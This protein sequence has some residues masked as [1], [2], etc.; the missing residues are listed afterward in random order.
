MKAKLKRMVS[1]C[2]CLTGGAGRGLLL[3]AGA[4]RAFALAVA[5]CAGGSAAFAGLQEQINSASDGTTLTMSADHEDDLT[6]SEAKT[7]NIDMAGHKITG[8]VTTLNGGKLTFKNGDMTCATEFTGPDVLLEKGVRCTCNQKAYLDPEA[9]PKLLM[10][11]KKPW[12]VVYP[13]TEIVAERESDRMQYEDLKTAFSVVKDGQTIRLLTD[14]REDVTVD[15]TVTFDMQGHLLKGAITAQN[16]GTPRTNTLQNVN[17]TGDL[18]AQG[19][20]RIVMQSG[21]NTFGSAFTGTNLEFAEDT[22]FGYKQAKEYIANDMAMAKTESD[23]WQVVNT[24][25]LEAA[26]GALTDDY[27]ERQAFLTAEDAVR[28]AGNGDLIRLLADQSEPIVLDMTAIGKNL[29][30]DA[31]GHLFASPALVG[32]TPDYVIATTK[33]GYLFLT[34]STELVAQL[35]D[36]SVYTSIAAAVAQS[37]NGG[38][39]TLLKDWT[40]DVTV[41]NKTNSFTLGSFTLNGN[42]KTT[43]EAGKIWFL[44]GTNTY[45]EK[46]AGPNVELMNGTFSSYEQEAY[47]TE[48]KTLANNVTTPPTWTIVDTND[49]VAITADGQKFVS[50]DLAMQ[51]AGNGETITFARAY[52]QAGEDDI[53]LDAEALAKNLKF[54]PKGYAFPGSLVYVG[55]GYTTAMDESYKLYLAADDAIVA[56]IAP[57][58]AFTTLATAVAVAKDGDTVEIVKTVNENVDVSGDKVISLTGGTNE[59]HLAF[60]SAT[61]KLTIKSGTYG[62][63]QDQAFLEDGNVFAKVAASLWEVVPEGDIVA[64]TDDGELYTSF[65]TAVDLNGDDTVISFYADFEGDIVLTPDEIAKVPKFNLNGKTFTGELKAASGVS[66]TYVV[67]TTAEGYLYLE[68]AD[69]IVAEIDGTDKQFASIAA[70]LAIA[71]DGEKIN[72]LKSW[73][74]D[75]SLSGQTNKL[76]LGAYE[77]TGDLTTTDDAGKIVVLDGTN[78]WERAFTGPNLELKPGTT[79]GFKQPADFLPSDEFALAK[80][81]ANRWTV[82]ETN[83]LAV[84][85]GEEKFKT[86]EEAIALASSGDTLVFLKKWDADVIVDADGLSKNLKFNPG[87]GLFDQDPMRIKADGYRLVQNPDR[88]FTLKP[89]GWVASVG[90]GDDYMEFQTFLDAMD[91]ADFI[92][93]KEITFL[94]DFPDD[95]LIPDEYVDAGFEFNPAG[96]AFPGELVYDENYTTAMNDATNLF[97]AATDDIV[98]VYNH[99]RPRFTNVVTAVNLAMNGTVVTVVKDCAGDATV[100]ADIT[101]ETADG[102]IYGGM[103]ETNGTCSLT[104]TLGSKFAQNMVDKFDW[105][106]MTPKMTLRHMLPDHDYYEVVL[107]DGTSV[108]DVRWTNRPT[109]RFASVQTAFDWLRKFIDENPDEAL[110]TFGIDVVGAGE[111][112]LD[113]GDRQLNW[114][115]NVFCAEA[116]ITVVNGEIYGDF[117]V[118]KGDV[119]TVVFGEGLLMTNK[120]PKVFKEPADPEAGVRLW[121]E[122]GVYKYDPTAYCHEGYVG[123]MYADRLYR[124]EAK[125][126]V[127]IVMTD[128]KSGADIHFKTLQDAFDAAPTLSTLRLYNN[129][130]IVA[131]NSSG[132]LFTLTSDPQGSDGNGANTISGGEIVLANGR[133]TVSNLVFD[134]AK[135]IVEDDGGILTAGNGLVMKNAVNGAVIVGENDR[136]ILDGNAQIVDN[137]GTNVLVKSTDPKSVVLKSCGDVLAG[138]GNYARVGIWSESCAAGEVFGTVDPT[139]EYGKSF[140]PGGDVEHTFSDGDITVAEPRVSFVND[141]DATLHHGK[142][143]TI[144]APA[145]GEKSYKRWTGG[146][147]EPLAEGDFLLYRTGNELVWTARQDAPAEE[148]DFAVIGRTAHTL[149]FLPTNGCDYAVVTNG[150][151]DTNWV[152]MVAGKTIAADGTFTFTNLVKFTDYQFLKRYSIT[153]SNIVSDVTVIGVPQST[154]SEDIDDIVRD[155]GF[156]PE[157]DFWKGY[158]TV[159][160]DGN[161]PYDGY[162]VTLKKDLR[163]GTVLPDDIGRLVINLNDSYISAE[164]GSN[165]VSFVSCEIEGRAF[166]DQ[167]LADVTVNG[168]GRVVGGKGTDGIDATNAKEGTRADK[169]AA[170]AGAGIAAKGCHDTVAL[171]L[172]SGVEVYGGGYIRNNAG[173]TFGNGGFGIEEDGGKGCDG[174]VGVGGDIALTVDGAFVKGG[175]GGDGGSS[176]KANGGDGG[177]GASAIGGKVEILKLKD[178]TFVGGKGGNG[179]NSGA[180]TGAAGNGGNGGN[181]L[182]IADA[183]K[184]EGNCSF[185]GGDAGKGGVGHNGAESGEDGERGSSGKPAAPETDVQDVVVTGESISFTAEPYMI[186]DLVDAGGNVIDTIVN[187]TDTPAPARF[188]DIGGALTPDTVYTIAS[189][190]TANESRGE[191]ESYAHETQVTTTFYTAADIVA[192]FQ[193]NAEVAIDDDGN[194]AITLTGDVAGG[195]RLPEDLGKVSL[196]LAGKTIAGKDGEVGAPGENGTAAV[197][198]VASANVPK[199]PVLIDLTLVGD[200]T[201]AGGQ[202]GDGK[203]ENPLDS[204]NGGD[205]APAIANESTVDDLKVVL[206]GPT[207]QGG[208]GGK[209]DDALTGNGGKGGRG[210]DAVG[211]RI[212]IEYVSGKAIGGNGGDGGETRDK[213]A[214]A[215]GG[216]GGN[217]GT[218]NVYDANGDFVSD[219]Q[220]GDGGYGGNGPVPGNVDPVSGQQ[221]DNAG[222]GATWGVPGGIVT[223]D[224]GEKDVRKDI[225]VRIGDADDVGNVRYYVSLEDALIDAENATSR[226]VYAIRDCAL[227]DFEVLT[228]GLTLATEG[229]AKIT[230]DGDLTVDSGL[231]FTVAPGCAIETGTDGELVVCGDV[232]LNAGAFAKVTVQNGGSLWVGGGEIAE[233][234]VQ[235]GG[236]AVIGDACEIGDVTVAATGRFT[237]ELNVDVQVTGTISAAEP[238]EVFLFG[239]IYAED[240]SAY[241]RLPFVTEGE[242][243]LKVVQDPSYVAMGVIDNEVAPYKTVDEAFAAIR[244][245]TRLIQVELLQDATVTTVL[246]NQPKIMAV[247]VGNGHTLTDA[248]EDSEDALFNL[249]GHLVIMDLVVDGAGQNADFLR[250]FESKEVA[251]MGCKITGYD[252]RNNLGQGPVISAWAAGETGLLLWNTEITGNSCSCA[253]STVDPSGSEFVHP[254]HVR[255][256]TTITEN[257]GDTGAAP[258]IVSDGYGQIVMDDNLTGGFID[259]AYKGYGE[260]FG[261]FAVAANDQ[262]SGAEKFRYLDQKT[263]GKIVVEA[264]GSAVVEWNLD[265]LQH[266][267][268]ILRPNADPTLPPEEIFEEDVYDAFYDVEDGDTIVLYRDLTVEEELPTWS[269]SFTLDLNGRTFANAG[270][271]LK[272]GDGAVKIVKGTLAAES[273]YALYVSGAAV[274]L[275]AD[276]TVDGDVYVRTGRLEAVEPT[277]GVKGEIVKTNYGTVELTEGR[278]AEDPSDYLASGRAAAGIDEDGYLFKIV[279]G[280]VASGFDAG[281]E[282]EV[283]FGTDGKVTV[284]LSDGAGRLFSGVGGS[285]VDIPGVRPEDVTVIVPN[286][287]WIAKVVDDGNGGAKVTFEMDPST[288]EPVIVSEDPGERELV[289]DVATGKVTVSFKTAYEGFVYYL[290]EADEPNGPFSM[291]G[292]SKVRATA[293]GPMSLNATFTLGAQKFFK[294]ALSDRW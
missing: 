161:Y 120:V 201:L 26:I 255:G 50:F 183:G 88:T 23:R 145:S 269:V 122:K 171:E 51:H 92:G 151:A 249:S 154:S 3:R 94:Q 225:L 234:D 131:T 85:I 174:K 95:I 137:V 1:Y 208:N 173:E 28:L 147:A 101:F 237:V 184:A 29:L 181:G 281:Y 134:T 176:T 180:E 140:V 112:T 89:L 93:E 205:G 40:E 215:Q 16:T 119:G 211:A 195:V 284:D 223:D 78:A 118:V 109:E 282:P 196:D 27:Q 96:F 65:N 110:N 84:A 103:L 220:G 79:Y 2:L 129:G 8:N 264:D 233:L 86:P 108:A 212:V 153:Q 268:V 62:Y 168:P 260:E 44:D 114:P 172:T 60:S 87:N 61:D 278:Y 22:V 106:A 203:A 285:E 59:Y 63:K 73:S 270:N 160:P 105:E 191:A 24:N 294:V 25:R 214:T 49:I 102:V 66:G 70:A 34:P 207:L 259:I 252:C 182:D 222:G 53:T 186:Y 213:T 206:D 91:Y 74:E 20:L 274:T 115:I 243:P 7:V 83:A 253:I 113:L 37:E 167:L 143:A 291:V 4:V 267:A 189:R 158:L 126:D 239:G 148:P 15:K 57:R 288:L 193:D 55:G 286:A 48:G 263:C 238:K 221:L 231:T 149:S 170:D 21:T 188:G 9:L 247:I 123:A 202:G 273:G 244:K 265:P 98:A 69:D 266:D 32:P 236:E 178:A 217:G 256:T 272:F 33:E 82:V 248:R 10:T 280:G 275:G 130:P 43:G 175:D 97:L 117:P 258:G 287:G 164:N 290:L 39:V 150:M 133:L 197:T 67:A 136:F 276:V 5:L 283:T 41:A 100:T 17:M 246:E 279:A 99:Y 80:T 185:N 162:V 111:H 289:F 36:G 199:N 46:F 241:V 245:S 229:D 125:G 14:V 216:N 45:T 235:D 139:Y 254:V 18:K 230:L 242:N 240:P 13:A 47:V 68:E 159:V 232:E 257:T 198:I 75:V 132:R 262:L 292:D 64:K 11:Y 72:L 146:F 107:D 187:D 277:V 261:K 38:T 104:T 200:G 116:T 227:D 169:T 250:L 293:T 138:E 128:R 155:F 251:L 135:I 90:E 19:D 194:Y 77:L 81:A 127:Q 58:L 141:R 210:G 157:A 71:A 54:D 204:R 12:F 166:R 226:N 156:D 219:S 224:D 56:K 76:S 165:G 271:L 218:A 192:M 42:F 163:K 124:I 228:D 31:N 179:G 35:D 6:I 52:D 152:S 209:G 190:F 177:N 144:A 142:G 30:F 121:T